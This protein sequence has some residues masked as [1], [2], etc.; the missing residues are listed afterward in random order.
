MTSGITAEEA[1]ATLKYLYAHSHEVEV[2][3]FEKV[4]KDL[5]GVENCRAGFFAVLRRN[6]PMGVG[7]KAVSPVLHEND[8]HEHSADVWYPVKESKDL[9]DKNVAAAVH[10]L[11]GTYKKVMEEENRGRLVGKYEL[12]M[13]DDLMRNQLK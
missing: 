9:T 8:S 3:L 6:G 1:S 4:P 2:T 11:L 7:I 5:S 12:E 10:N 13:V